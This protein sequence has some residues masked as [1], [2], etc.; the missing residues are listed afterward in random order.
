[1]CNG[2]PD[3]DFVGGH[4]LVH[5][6]IGD[7]NRRTL[8]RRTIGRVWK[9][10]RN[11]IFGNQGKVSQTEFTVNDGAIRIS[12]APGLNESRGQSPGLR[13]LGTG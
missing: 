5:Q 12:V 9:G 3:D 11:P 10:C 13:A 7:G 6:F 2:S 1:L 8:R 4:Q